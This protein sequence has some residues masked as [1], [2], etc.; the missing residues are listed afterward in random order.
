MPFIQPLSRSFL[1]LML[2]PWDC[3]PESKTHS[4]KQFRKNKS[5]TQSNLVEVIKIEFSETTLVSQSL[6]QGLRSQVF[7]ELLGRHN[8]GGDHDRMLEGG[9]KM[10]RKTWHEL[11]NS[12]KHK[13]LLKKKKKKQ[14]C[15]INTKS[16][17]KKSQKGESTDQIMLWSLN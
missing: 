14:V 8:E 6:A 17:H 4:S 5:G 12:A 16:T 13:T 1:L 2:P 15:S 9:E 11:R 3:G 7:L 10:L